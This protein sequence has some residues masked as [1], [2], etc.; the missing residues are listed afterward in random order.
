MGKI[1]PALRAAFDYR[2]GNP[3]HIA[4]DGWVRQLI[5]MI[6]YAPSTTWTEVPFTVETN[7]PG[8][9]QCQL[10]GRDQRLRITEVGTLVKMDP[11]ERQVIVFA[12]FC[13]FAKFLSC[14]PEFAVMLTRLC[15]GVMRV[16]G[17]AR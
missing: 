4:L 6:R 8:E 17:N 12:E 7:F 1:Q 5:F 3:A 11:F 16:D 9:I 15:V 14:H 13:R 2:L 10:D